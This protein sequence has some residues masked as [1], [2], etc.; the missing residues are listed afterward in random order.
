VHGAIARIALHL[1]VGACAGTGGSAW[2]QAQDLAKRA[3]E[4]RTQHDMARKGSLIEFELARSGLESCRR[5]LALADREW[6]EAECHEA[7]RRIDACNLRR[8]QWSQALERFAQDSLAAGEARRHATLLKSTLPDCP[9]TVPGRQA[10][11]VEV[12]VEESRRERRQLP[13]FSVCESHLRALLTATDQG[14][15]ALA[16][17]LAQDLVAQCGADHPD[18]RRQAEAALIRSGLDPAVVL[19]RV[20]PA[21]PAASAASTP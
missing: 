8:E 4:L 16:R 3:A 21:V 10:G 17:S 19:A 1:L 2:S 12:L 7:Q 6:R 18:Y 11:P 14:N 13:G 20:R 5:A 15:A 9:S